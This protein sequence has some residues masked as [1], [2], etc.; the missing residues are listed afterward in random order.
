MD[1]A[2]T[3][4]GRFAA[5]E[6][7]PYGRT[8]PAGKPAIRSRLLARL[9]GPAAAAPGRGLPGNSEPLPAP[10]GVRAIPSSSSA[11]ERRGPLGL[12]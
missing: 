5:C 4:P 2:A 12:T 6:R 3:V 9:L 1:A 8:I 10:R 11:E 7:P